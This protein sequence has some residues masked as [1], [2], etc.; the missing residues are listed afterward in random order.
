MMEEHQTEQR[1]STEYSQNVSPIERDE[2][3]LDRADGPPD[4]REE[5]AN[6]CV[7]TKNN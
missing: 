7:C 4:S 1:D 5:V 2:P 6:M 3:L